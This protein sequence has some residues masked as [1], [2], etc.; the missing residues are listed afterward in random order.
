M[1]SD[2]IDLD[3]ME[4]TP[5]QAVKLGIQMHLA[6]L[7]LSNTTSV[8]ESMGVERS[9]KAVHDRVHKA[10]LQPDDGR[11]PDHVAIDCDQINDKRFWLYAAID[12]RKNHLLH[13]R[14]FHSTTTVAT[15]MFIRELVACRR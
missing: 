15:Q 13:V 11:S 14:L 3:F 2:W 6:G 8:L 9:R 12:P 7:S 4:R 5:E 10:N 1:N